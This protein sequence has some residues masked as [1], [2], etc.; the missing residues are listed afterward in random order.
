MYSST[1]SLTSA[2]DKGG[3]SASLPG[4]FTS[5]SDRYRLYGR[6]G[7]PQVP[8]GR[9]QKSSPPPGFDLRAA[10]SVASCYTDCGV[11]AAFVHRRV[12]NMYGA[13]DKV[14]EQL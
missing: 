3:S 10:Q 12:R 11:P 5:G 9:V 6:F 1:P 8:S 7:G 13:M 4:H 2:L 14:Q